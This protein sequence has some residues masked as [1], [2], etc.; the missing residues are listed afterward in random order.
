MKIGRLNTKVNLTLHKAL[1]RSVTTCT[2]P[3][4]RIY[5]RHPSYGIVAPGKQDSPRLGKFPTCISIR[6]LHVSVKNAYVY[7]FVKKLCT[8]ITH[9]HTRSKI[10]TGYLHLLTGTK[11]DAIY[12]L[13]DP[14]QKASWQM[15]SFSQQTSTVLHR[16]RPPGHQL[17]R[18]EWRL[19]RDGDK[20][21]QHNAASSQRIP[22]YSQSSS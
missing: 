14:I 4:L 16:P 1:T 6:D 15:N 20:Y 3:C 12:R 17:L 10:I 7:H 8:F 2:H 22:H 19:L 11:P 9:K 21:P 18:E 13:L 5:G